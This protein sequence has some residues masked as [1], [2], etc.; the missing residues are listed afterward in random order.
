MDMDALWWSAESLDIPT[1]KVRRPATEDTEEAVEKL[2]RI[3]DLCWV[4]SGP[5]LCDAVTGVSWE[6]F[7]E[8][9]DADPQAMLKW[10]RHT[11]F[12]GYF[13]GQ[14]TM[15]CAM[16][17]GRSSS[18][19]AWLEK[20]FSYTLLTSLCYNPHRQYTMKINARALDHV[21]CIHV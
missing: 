2:V 14:L 18:C 3:E 6:E 1:V 4:L 9:R 21:T 20:S 5:A 7:L 13:V 19:I 17:T 15:H 16:C 8:R 10:Q 11:Q 12:A